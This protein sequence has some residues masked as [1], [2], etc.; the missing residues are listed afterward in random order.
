VIAATATV[1]IISGT[2]ASILLSR[3]KIEVM[4]K[5]DGV[6][7]GYNCIANTAHPCGAIRKFTRSMLSS[8][9]TIPSGS[10]QSNRSPRCGFEET[11]NWYKHRVPNDCSGRR[12]AVVGRHAM[13]SYGKER[14][15][16][17]TLWFL[18]RFG[19]SMLD[20]QATNASI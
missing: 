17:G 18:R 2:S 9:C 13:R 8:G 7:H 3:E 15:A 20:T 6:A 1:S 12:R 14:I 10:V 11:Y 4:R 5:R 19:K 16:L